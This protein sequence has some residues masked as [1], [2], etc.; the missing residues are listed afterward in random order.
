M[1]N[2]VDGVDEEGEGCEVRKGW[3]GLSKGF[4]LSFLFLTS[5]FH[6]ISCG[7]GSGGVG[8]GACIINRQE[9]AAIFVCV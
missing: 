8:G 5:S 1:C 6:I 4:F 3:R 9:V 7:T 2:G